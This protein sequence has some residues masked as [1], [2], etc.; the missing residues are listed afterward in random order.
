[1][2][3]VTVKDLIKQLQ[4]CPQDA[5][6]VFSWNGNFRPGANLCITDLYGTNNLDLF[7]IEN[8]DLYEDVIILYSDRKYLE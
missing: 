8:E 5:R 7:E 2:E 6:V 1:M 3:I 4:T